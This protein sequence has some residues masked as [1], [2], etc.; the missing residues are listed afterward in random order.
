MEFVGRAFLRWKEIKAKMNS[1]EL[2]QALNDLELLKRFLQ[3]SRQGNLLT[4][5]SHLAI[6][7]EIAKIQ[8]AVDFAQKNQLVVGKE[9]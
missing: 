4:T 5:T 8:E 6:R 9:S 3:Y 7:R 1:Q 2:N